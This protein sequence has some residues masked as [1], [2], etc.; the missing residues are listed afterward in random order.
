MPEGS[1]SGAVACHAHTTPGTAARTGQESTELGKG[2]AR[3]PLGHVRSGSRAARCP[4]DVTR[5]TRLLMHLSSRRVPEPPAAEPGDGAAGAVSVTQSWADRGCFRA[6]CHSP[7][8]EAGPQGQAVYIP[9]SYL[10]AV[11]E[12]TEPELGASQEGRAGPGDAGLHTGE[13]GHD[14]VTVALHEALSSA[15]CT[16]HPASWALL[17]LTQAGVQSGRNCRDSR[18]VCRSTV[19]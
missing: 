12:R 14:A 4:A 8:S 1:G 11:C 10:R 17:C 2:L 18:L 3:G 15:G 7:L 9:Y 5:L 16:R 6:W 19:I 13:H